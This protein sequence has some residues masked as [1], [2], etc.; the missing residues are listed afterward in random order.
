MKKNMNN[1]VAKKFDYEKSTREFA[2]DLPWYAE[3]ADGR[4]HRPCQR[5]TLTDEVYFE[6]WNEHE[7]E[8][9]LM[10]EDPELYRIIWCLNLWL[11]SQKNKA[12]RLP[13]LMA[14]CKERLM[15]AA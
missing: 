9:T 4:K 13:S 10:V 2:I 12:S 3:I 7:F 14:Y 6:Y 1:V 5:F 8:F 11:D 15:A